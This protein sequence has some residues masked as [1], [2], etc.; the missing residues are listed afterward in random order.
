MTGIST[1]TIAPTAL[2]YGQPLPF[3]PYSTVSSSLAGQPFQLAQ[4]TAA[5]VV[6]LLQIV[7]QQ[8][9][10]LQYT[11]QQQLQQLQWLLQIVPQQLQSLQ[12]LVQLLP[13]QVQ[14]PNQPQLQS[15]QFGV[16]SPG[17]SGFPFGA[18][19]GHVM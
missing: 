9:Q 18:H 1:S 12:Q 13:Q 17:L 3:G 5:S 14:Q 2:P 6:Q 19:A 7:P 8:L 15:P 11:Q 16:A 10:Q 4:P